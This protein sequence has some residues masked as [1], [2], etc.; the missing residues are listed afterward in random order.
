[1]SDFFNGWP[2]DGE[3]QEMTM[4]EPFSTVL[5]EIA[6]APDT[7]SPYVVASWCGKAADRIA[8]LE[9]ENERLREALRDVHEFCTCDAHIIANAALAEKV[10]A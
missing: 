3:P 9:A 7:F 2:E 10:D 6:D 4:S 1:M 5:R 8:E